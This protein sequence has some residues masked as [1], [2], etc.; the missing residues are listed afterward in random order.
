MKRKMIINPD[1]GGA[2]TLHPH[3]LLQGRFCQLRSYRWQSSQCGV[4]RQEIMSKD[5]LIKLADLNIP[6]RFEQQNRVYSTHGISPTL[7]AGM[8]HGGNCIP[9]FLIVKKI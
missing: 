5:K 6:G 7:N 2:I 4:N 3:K 1:V 8:G 9:L